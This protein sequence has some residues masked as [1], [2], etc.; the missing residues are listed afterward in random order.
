MEETVER[1]NDLSL[2]LHLW[3]NQPQDT[4]PQRDTAVVIKGGGDGE[5]F[6]MWWLCICY[7]MKSNFSK[8]RVLCV[9]CVEHMHHSRSILQIYL[10]ARD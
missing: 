6:T 7:I 8:I 9:R 1:Q 3:S 5:Q 4:D 2:D 10:V